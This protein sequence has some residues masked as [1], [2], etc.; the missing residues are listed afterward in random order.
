MRFA[1]VALAVLFAGVAQA[2]TRSYV[3]SSSSGRVYISSY[4]TE[5]ASNQSMNKTEIKL[6][7]L[8]LMGEG[9]IKFDISDLNV[10]I[11]KRQ[12]L[13]STERSTNT[14]C[15]VKQKSVSSEYVQEITF[16]K[17][18]GT[19]IFEDDTPDT[20][21]KSVKAIVLCSETATDSWPCP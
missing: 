11:S 13:S 9:Q 14:I 19:T 17:K 8:G 16:S 3:C 21:I 20:A 15:K 5:V 12:M 7:T 10:S 4:H 1:L 2:Q 18:D 6:K